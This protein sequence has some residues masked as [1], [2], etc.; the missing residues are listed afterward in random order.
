VSAFLRRAGAILT[1]QQESSDG[2]RR[3]ERAP[4]F[5]ATSLR[6]DWYPKLDYAPSLRNADFGAVLRRVDAF[7]TTRLVLAIFATVTDVLGVLPAIVFTPG[8]RAPFTRP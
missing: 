1:P 8:A 6:A 5:L 7:A 3:A 4:T 2:G